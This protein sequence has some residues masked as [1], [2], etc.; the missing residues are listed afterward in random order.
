MR[1]EMIENVVING[2]P[3]LKG[4]L[5]TAGREISEED[6]H[7]ALRQNW[8]VEVGEKKPERPRKAAGLKTGGRVT[9]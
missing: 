3:G 2:W 6:A 4:Q 1:I 9:K 5:L 7:L 8:A